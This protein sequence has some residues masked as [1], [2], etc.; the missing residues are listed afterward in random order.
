MF[1]GVD[2]TNGVAV[3]DASTVAELEPSVFSYFLAANLPLSDQDRLQLLRCDNVVQRLRLCIE[4]IQRNR[5]KSLGCAV[6]KNKLT[7]IDQVFA[8]PGA[9]GVVGAYVNPHG[10]VTPNRYY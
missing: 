5:G 4:Y 6:C 9:E 3:Y 10:L 7:S 2:D 8:V 1:P